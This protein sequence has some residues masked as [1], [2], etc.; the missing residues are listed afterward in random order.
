MYLHLRHE[1]E[2]TYSDLISESVVE[3]R[4]APRQ[5]THQ[6]RLSFDLSVGPP[7]SVRS[8]LD[9][10]G[11]AVHAFNVAG[12]HD[13]LRFVAESV[14]EVDRPETRLEL[15]EDAWPY[16]PGAV[17]WDLQEY[18]AF[19]GAVVDSLDLRAL[20]GELHAR[21][22][23]PVGALAQRMLDVL[24]DKFTYRKGVTTVA[25]PVTEVLAH[26]GGVCQDFTHVMLALA[27]VLGVPARYVSGLLHND[28]FAREDDELRGAA[29]SHAWCELWTPTD[30][31]VGVDPTNCCT[32]DNRFVSVAVG[33][34]YRDVAPNRGVYRGRADERL[35][36]RVT[37]RALDEVPEE[38]AAERFGTIGV[39]VSPG[40]AS[41]RRLDA[42][43]LAQAH[44]QQQ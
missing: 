9:W 29:E 12:F 15:L 13:E 22:G 42:R 44:Q 43:A 25:S 33:R 23:E 2:L 16:T 38:L 30:G 18:V 24:W 7:T 37:T 14:V 34:D 8:Y 1:T 31:W 26:K 40:W 20:A 36:V 3:L 11:N 39:P 4:V 28:A 27:R 17:S 19:G 41:D 35:R 21:D 6:H 5:D 10:L 32:V